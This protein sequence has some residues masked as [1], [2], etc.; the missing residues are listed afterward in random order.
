VNTAHASVA[1]ILMLPT[2]IQQQLLMTVHVISQDVFSQPL[3]T[4]MRVQR[5][6]MEVANTLLVPVA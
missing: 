1:P 6:P 5:H 4:T 3:V 2:T